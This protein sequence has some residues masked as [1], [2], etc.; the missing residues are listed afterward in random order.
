MNEKEYIG[1]PRKTQEKTQE[2][3]RQPRKTKD[4]K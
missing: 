2:N 3:I 4:N 1:Q